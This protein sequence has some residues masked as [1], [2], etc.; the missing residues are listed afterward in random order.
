MHQGWVLKDIA[1]VLP[2]LDQA[3]VQAIAFLLADPPI[4]FAASEERHPPKVQA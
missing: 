2:D 3:T 4:V 1:K